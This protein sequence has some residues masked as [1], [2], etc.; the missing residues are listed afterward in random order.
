MAR[1]ADAS[2]VVYGLL[3]REIRKLWMYLFVHLDR[4]WG[5]VSIS[6]KGQRVQWM[7]GWVCGQ[8]ICLCRLS[9]YCV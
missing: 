3:C 8:N 2:N 5:H 4:R 6:L 1:E 7:F 9:I